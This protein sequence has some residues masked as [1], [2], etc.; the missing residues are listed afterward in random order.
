[1]TSCCPGIGHGEPGG[2]ER[3]EQ[4]EYRQGAGFLKVLF[5]GGGLLTDCAAL[6]AQAGSSKH[7]EAHHRETEWAQRDKKERK[8][9]QRGTK[10]A[11]KSLRLLPP[12]PQGRH[13]RAGGYRDGQPCLAPLSGRVNSK[14]SMHPLASTTRL[15]GIGLGSEFIS[16]FFRQL[17]FQ[18]GE[19]IALILIAIPFRQRQPDKGQAL[20]VLDV[21][22]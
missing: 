21:S 7:R 10:C 4:I 1:M 5:A 6:A 16:F 3:G 17:P 9:A 13:T 18:L 15:P 22:H 14:L 19:Q 2:Q 12:R 20:V 8:G 11:E